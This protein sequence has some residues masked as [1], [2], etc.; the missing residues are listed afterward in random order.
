[1]LIPSAT[2]R[3]V[4]AVPRDALILREDNT[5]IF[6]VDKKNVATRVAVETGAED[7]TLVEVKGMVAP[8]DHVIVRGAERLEQGQKVRPVA[9]S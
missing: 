3:N 2:P 9:S 5:Y 1:M 6:K 7:G 8:G 4:L